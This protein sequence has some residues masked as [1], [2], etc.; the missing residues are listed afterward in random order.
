M[1]CLSLIRKTVRFMSFKCIESTIG[2]PNERHVTDPCYVQM[3]A[4]EK[5]QSDPRSPGVFLC[6][7][8]RYDRYNVNTY[9]N[10]HLKV[11]IEV[12][13]KG[14]HG[15]G[16]LDFSF[17]GNE[18]DLEDNDLNLSHEGA[19]PELDG[20]AAVQTPMQHLLGPDTKQTLQ[21]LEIS[22]SGDEQSDEVGL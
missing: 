16:D 2:L 8:T 7:C 5:G 1:L 22:F 20:L 11:D 4:G 18:G 12:E 3:Y 17:Q 19:L 21:D 14:E 15:D 9:M 6:C 10:W 13:P